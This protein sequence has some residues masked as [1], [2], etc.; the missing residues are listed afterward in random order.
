[1]SDASINYALRKTPI[2]IIGMGSVFPGATN[3]QE[4]WDNIVKEIDSITEV[5]PSRWEIDDYYDPDPLAPD[6]T[7][8]KRGGFPTRY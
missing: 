4:Y 6:K 2:A 5:P 1:M 8:C 3:L 7:Y